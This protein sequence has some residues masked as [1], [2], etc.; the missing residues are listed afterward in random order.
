MSSNT[1][2]L[3]VAP[4]L[5]ER[6]STNTGEARHTETN[7]QVGSVHVGVFSVRAS[8]LAA[9]HTDFD[10]LLA[11]LESNPENASELTEAGRWV[12]DVWLPEGETLRTIRRRK[13]LSQK[14]LAEIIGSTQPHLS[15]IESGKGDL[16][17]ETVVKLCQALEIS[18][19]DFQKLKLNKP[20][21]KDAN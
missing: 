5:I 11:E 19:D 20:A 16:M 2:R 13:G 1:L 8:D 17:F 9:A 4:A 21:A 15:N 12:A 7:T 6:W 18:L 14:R 10:S 3:N